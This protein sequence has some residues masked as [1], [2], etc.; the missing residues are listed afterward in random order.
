[1]G[2]E[3]MGDYTDSSE[4]P[5]ACFA[6]AGAGSGAPKEILC[7]GSAEGLEGRSFSG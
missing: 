6:G 5:Q 1:M 4:V 2:D 3:V 7:P